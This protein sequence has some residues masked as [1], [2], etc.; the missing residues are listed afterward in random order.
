[1]LIVDVSQIPSE[2]LD[3]SSELDPVKLHLGADES[4]RLEPGARLRC[5]LERGDDDAVHV[6][7]VLDVGIGLDCGRCLEAFSLTFAHELDLFYLPHREGQTEE[8]DDEVELSDHEVV[9]GYYR[10]G[11]LDLGDVVREQLF[12]HLPMRRVCRDD[13]RGLCPTCG[14]NRN[15][16]RCAC[17]PAAEVD[18]RLAGL[19]RLLDKR[20]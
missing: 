1:M 4:F 6:R 20:R 8:E 18:P 2:G 12:L 13:C 5:R 9:V 14:V 11:R 16:T 19:A 3:V 15:Q 7:G 17:A 10:D